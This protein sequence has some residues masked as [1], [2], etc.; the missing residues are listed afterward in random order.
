MRTYWIIW[1]DDES[2]TG[3]NQAVFISMYE[4]ICWFDDTDLESYQTEY[5]IKT[6]D[7]FETWEQAAEFITSEEM[8]YKG[9]HVY[10]IEETVLDYLQYEHREEQVDGP[11][12]NFPPLDLPSED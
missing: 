6:V 4:M 3:Y 11:Y 9:I 7:V 12:K 8:S 5:I 10:E 2:S 1:S